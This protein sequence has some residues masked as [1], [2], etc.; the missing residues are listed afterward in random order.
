MMTKYIMELTSMYV[1]K[2]SRAAILS[3]AVCC[4][5]QEQLHT[6]RESVLTFHSFSG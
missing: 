2:V 5:L 3:V 1:R 6:I 4:Q